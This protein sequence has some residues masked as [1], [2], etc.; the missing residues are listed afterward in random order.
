MQRKGAWTA[1]WAP[2]SLATMGAIFEKEG[3]AVKLNDCI[4]ENIDF[5]QLE[6]IIRQFSPSVVII[7]TATPSIESDLKV[8][9]LAKSIDRRILTVV[10]GIHVTALPKE[11]LEMAKDLDLVVRGEPEET[12]KEIAAYLNRGDRLENIKG[13]SYR[14]NGQ[15]IQQEDRPLV[16]NLDTF[17]FP[18]WHLV[19]ISKYT[20][21]FKNKPF[22][23][24]DTGRG[25][26]FNCTFCSA[27]AFYGHQV[28]LRSVKNLVD[29]LVY[30]KDKY[31]VDEFLFWTESF[32]LNNDY[33]KAVC[34]EIISRHLKI[35]F[36]CNS[37]VTGIDRELLALIKKA[38]GWMIGYGVESGSQ[39]ILDQA[40]KGIT[41]KQI[42]E[43]VNLAKEVGLDVTA[44]VIFGLPGETQETMRETLKFC[45]RLPLDY[46]QFYCAVPFPG[47]QFYQE[48]KQNNWLVD[49]RWPYLEQNFCVIDYFSLSSRQIMDFRRQ[50]FRKFYLRP[51]MIFKALGRID[52][53]WSI[54]YFFSM[55]KDFLTWI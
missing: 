25:C 46:A 43:A 41:L 52:S 40:K 50:A 54:K 21:P 8:A 27:A 11:T 15:I 34:R 55:L 2:I 10:F 36:V 20:L 26:P 7:N 22:L 24:V 1:V 18:A 5:R 30:I 37:R 23:L 45:L 28:R 3:Y 44:H 29:E 13:L 35:G 9:A 6:K 53:W 51:K 19:D 14:K 31:K 4:V 33:A 49:S 47:S 16:Q 48:A 42:E 38:G 12:V 32:T 17:P 39:K